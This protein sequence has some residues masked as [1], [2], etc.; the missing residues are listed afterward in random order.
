MSNSSSPYLNDAPFW[1]LLARRMYGHS[2]EE[3][4]PLFDSLNR[5]SKALG[6]PIV[7]SGVKAL[8]WAVVCRVFVFY[9]Q[10][11]SAMGRTG[12]LRMVN[13]SKQAF[14][15]GRFAPV[16]FKRLVANIAY[17]SSPDRTVTESIAD[18][19]LANGL[20]VTEEYNDS[21]WDDIILSRS[22]SD[23]EMMEL[24]DRIIRP[25]AGL[26]EDVVANY[27]RHRPGFFSRVFFNLK[28]WI[29]S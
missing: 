24:C 11:A 9:D 12:Y 2:E 22:L 18:T 27:G 23:A 4:Q 16:A 28:S 1:Y 15:H 21:S 20:T 17:P 26:W 3:L 10:R 19:F 8:S 25:P 5:R 6:L 14:S 13:G 7:F 29:L